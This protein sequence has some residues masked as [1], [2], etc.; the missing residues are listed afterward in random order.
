MGAAGEGGG[1]GG[2]GGERGRSWYLSREEIERGSPSRRDGVSAAQE[3]GL[4]TT[5]CSFIRDVCARLE[6]RHITFA[7]AVVLCHRFYLRQSLAKNEWQTVATVC[8]FLASKIEDTPCPLQR[9][10]I[11]AYETMYNK[12][13]IAAIR[14]CQKEVLEKQKALILL[15]E[16]LLLSTIGFDFNIQHPYEPLKLAMKD[17]GVSQKEVGQ[18]AINLINDSL[19]TTLVVQFKPH[20]IAAGSLYLAAKIHNIR[21]PSKEGKVWWN[22]FDVAPR[23]LQAIMQQMT[24]LFKKR[25]P[26]LMGSSANKPTPVPTPTMSTPD[27][28]WK[29]TL[30]SRI[31]CVPMDRSLDNKSKGSLPRNEE[32]QSVRTHLNHTV[33]S[34]AIPA[35]VPAPTSKDKQHIIR[36]PNPALSHTQSSRIRVR[37]RDTEG[38]RCVPVAVDRSLDNNST[39]SSARNEENQSVQTHLNHT[40]KPNAI[41]TSA[42][43]PIPVQ[44]P[45]SKD[46]QRIISA[47]DSALGHTQSSRTRTSD[48]EG[49]RC[50]PVERPLNSKST[51][52]SARN[53]E[54]QSLQTHL[55]H[56]IKPTKTPK[57]VPTLM[58]K[59][60]IASSPNPS[61]SYTQSSRSCV[62]NSDIEGSR[63]V[64]VDRL[65]NNEFT[66]SSRMNE[67]NQ[68]LQTHMNHSLNIVAVDRRFGKQYSRG[69]RGTLKAD[70]VYHVCSGPKD[71]DV[72]RIK[73]LTR[74]KRG[75]QEVGGHPAPVDD[76][77]NWIGK[78]LRSVIVV[79][80]DSSW[81]KQKVERG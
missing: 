58:D 63:C 19:R 9:V 66:G 72:T 44:V 55:N 35:P 79:E 73:D 39:C 13:P 54:N 42:P 41:P 59:P 46:K 1:G 17:L 49:S 43:A 61:L 8:V 33:K 6:L 4:R 77:V 70:P 15:G 52:S 57:P 68:S 25:N 75:I 12:N 34:T 80:T 50:V 64:P 71:I 18:T 76:K 32:N 31:R 10:V 27:P 7:T 60:R 40:V 65:L 62:R 74:Q 22:A 67:D 48:T 36:A 20:Y 78:Q 5:Y 16:T 56:T 53:G 3:A 26:C 14:I 2:D 11:V 69:T 21:L 28:S 30:S 45:T 37:N 47:P 23:Q 24:E 29:H 51:S 38:S 81:K